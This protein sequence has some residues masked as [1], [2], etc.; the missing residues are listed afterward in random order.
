MK[1]RREIVFLLLGIALAGALNF[2]LV[3]FGG[4]KT[5]L[6]HRT[7]I[8]DP[9]KEIA[10]IEIDRDNQ[11]AIWMSC[12]EKSV[13]RLIKPY[14][15]SV[16]E[17]VINRFLDVLSTEVISDSLSDRDLLRIGRQRAD[18]EL[19]N[20]KFVI[21]LKD[22]EGK[23][24]D[25]VA[26]GSVTPSGQS[27][28]ASIEGEQS[29]ITVS[30]NLFATVNVPASGFRK[31]TLFDI[32][33]K[34]VV[35]FEVHRPSGNNLT[36]V[37]DGD[38]LKNPNIDG[39]VNSKA[40]ELLEKMLSLTAVNFHWPTG[41]T[42]ESNS[43]TA[44]LLAGYGLDSE[45]AVVVNMKCSDGTDRRI[46]LG[47][48]GGDSLVYALAQGDSAV[49]SVDAA[50]RDLAMQSEETFVD[51]RLFPMEA[52]AVQA[53]TLVESDV[54][55]VLKRVG[56]DKWM[57]DSPIVV[58]ADSA[59]AKLVLDRIL[60]LSS[61]DVIKD[62]KNSSVPHI[63]VSLTTN[64]PP[65]TVAATSVLGKNRI[66]QLRSSEILR[67]DP[68]VVKRI[69]QTTGDKGENVFAVV[70]DREKRRWNREVSGAIAPGEVNA[71]AVERLLSAINPLK[72]DRIV[73]LKVNAEDEV[74]YGLDKPLL[75][76]A[77]DQDSENSLRR[78]IIIGGQAKGGR[79]A[80]VGSSDAIFVIP[81][82]TVRKLSTAL[83][84]D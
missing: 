58:E 73:T 68:L 25:R 24:V 71:K 31:K 55:Y 49:V 45:S 23:T 14:P 48:R 52:S 29:V 60:S 20:P 17:T 47:K 38:I 26:F 41:A 57:I 40:V 62:E 74:K 50:A 3:M 33:A 21:T 13:W 81:T 27:V 79:Y 32:D 42:N 66:A 44:S 83:G 61:S 69:V 46:T 43:V 84:N 9:T 16:E 56:N 63:A 78:N 19:D 12:Q 76:I 65:A 6:V 4:Q 7:T 11:P 2:I 67:F 5:K 59:A 72:A 10:F 64:M 36:F 80:T 54:T 37:R 82:A 34:S 22:G 53:F 18:F 51:S 15:G 77:I 30:S 75:K 39:S 28:Y 70:Y 8:L 1:N 35:S